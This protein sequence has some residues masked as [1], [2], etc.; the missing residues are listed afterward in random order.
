MS[1][2]RDWIC[3][4]TQTEAAEPKRR[5]EAGL[6]KGQ[7][8]GTAVAGRWAPDRHQTGPAC[9]RSHYLGKT[10]RLNL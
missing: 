2:N 3:S 10:S 6:S 4:D 1:W 9:A 7:L 5:D 8:D